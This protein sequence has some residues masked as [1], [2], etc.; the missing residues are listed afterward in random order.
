MTSSLVNDLAKAFPQAREVGR[1]VIEGAAAA[2]IVM[3]ST[4]LR[5]MTMLPTS[6]VMRVRPPFAEMSMIS[7]APLPLNSMAS[8]PA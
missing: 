4:S 8:V 1:I 3:R 6:R 5:S 2:L 7:L